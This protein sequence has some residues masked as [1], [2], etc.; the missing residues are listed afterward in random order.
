MMRNYEEQPDIFVSEKLLGDVYSVKVSGKL[1]YDFYKNSGLLKVA[2]PQ[3]DLDIW[4]KKFG[5]IPETGRDLEMPVPVFKGELA[6]HH[7]VF[8]GVKKIES[9]GK[10]YFMFAPKSP[11]GGDLM[12]GLIRKIFR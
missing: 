1:L 11:P 2:M 8:K 7:V 9:M 6:G 5:G 12:E 3:N 4:V 10:D